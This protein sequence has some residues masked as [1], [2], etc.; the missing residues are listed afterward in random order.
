MIVVGNRVS[1]GKRQN[2]LGTREKNVHRGRGED[3]IWTDFS[4]AEERMLQYM[5]DKAE[6]SFC[7]PSQCCSDQQRLVVIMLKYL[8]PR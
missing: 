3:T 5:H 4:V 2:V 6:P 7:R 8:V 1:I